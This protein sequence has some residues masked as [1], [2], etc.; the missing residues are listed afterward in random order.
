MH[1]A[2]SFMAWLFPRI[3]RNAGFLMCMFITIIA[4]PPLVE[5][6][7]LVREQQASATVAPVPVRVG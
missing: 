4:F 7:R 6:R 2:A 3:I 1:K 5:G